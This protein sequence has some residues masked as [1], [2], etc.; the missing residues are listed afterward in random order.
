MA[1]MA[2][3]PKPRPNRRFFVPFRDDMDKLD[4]LI[5]TMKPYRFEICTAEKEP[6]GY[7]DGHG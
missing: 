3:C 7:H 1:G 5:E 4:T 6:F 2:S